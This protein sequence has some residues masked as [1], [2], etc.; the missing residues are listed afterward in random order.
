MNVLRPVNLRGKVV[1]NDKKCQ[2]FEK[3]VRVNFLQKSTSAGPK[4][5]KIKLNLDV[6]DPQSILLYVLRVI[7]VHSGASVMLADDGRFDD[8]FL[9]SDIAQNLHIQIERAY[10]FQQSMSLHVDW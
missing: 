3:F 8:F 7:R 1:K 6:S 4:C 2:N 10:F 9:E 5:I